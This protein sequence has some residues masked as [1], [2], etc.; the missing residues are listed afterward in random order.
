MADKFSTT[1]PQ[2]PKKWRARKEFKGDERCTNLTCHTRP[3]SN[4][5]QVRGLLLLEE[6]HSLNQKATSTY[7]LWGTGLDTQPVSQQRHLCA[8]N[9]EQEPAVTPEMEQSASM[10]A[11]FHPESHQQQGPSQPVLSSQPLP[12]QPTHSPVCHCHLQA[13]S[14]SASDLKSG[15]SPGSQTRTHLHGLCTHSALSPGPPCEGWALCRPVHTPPA[16]HLSHTPPRQNQLNL[17]GE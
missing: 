8:Y 4:S 5:A 12:Q 14:P 2:S 16:S 6:R 1:C 10:P 13:N 11:F 17:P 15:I 3:S 7:K 9:R